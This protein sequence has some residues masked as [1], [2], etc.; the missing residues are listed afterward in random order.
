MLIALIFLL[1][2]QGPEKK[3]DEIRKKLIEQR[4]NV[5]ELKIRETGILKSIQEIDNEI[6]LTRKLVEELKKQTSFLQNEIKEIENLIIELDYNLMQKK[7]IL[8]KRV[9]NIYKYGKLHPLEIVLLSYSFDDALKRMKYLSIIAEQDMRLLKEIKKIKRLLEEK[10]SIMIKKLEDL[11]ALK[12]ESEIEEENL[13]R[14][15][16][17]KK[18][19][20]N[21][22]SSKREEAERMARELEK[23]E[24]DLKKLI[25]SLPKQEKGKVELIN[26]KLIFPVE[27]KIIGKFGF[28]KDPKYGTITKNNG[29]DIS[30][31]YGEPVKVISD[32]KVVFAENFLG[33]G[34]MVIV[35]HGNGYISLYAH[36]SIISVEVGDDLKQGDV[37][38]LV[39]D[40]G[41][42]GEPQL[43]FEIRRNGQPVDPMHFFGS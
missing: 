25:A 8:A 36:L 12:V 33:Y 11:D 42:L 43:H 9:R 31:P 29:I 21:Q 28:K 32:G 6:T 3:L 2:S 30:A 15:L 14:T 40:T 17:G 10:K 35:D 39:G 27:G 4:K 20:L 24:Q 41:S 16:I 38:G 5:Q 26:T 18:D 37:L 19:F 22:I 34:K 13:R 1:F 7:V 23:A